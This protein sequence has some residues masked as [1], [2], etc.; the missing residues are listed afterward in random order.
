LRTSTNH[1]GEHDP[2]EVELLAPRHARRVTVQ[3]HQ[4]WREA[5]SSPAPLDVDD[6][7]LDVPHPPEMRRAGDIKRLER[8]FD[9]L[10]GKR[11]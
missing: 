10:E 3:S 6:L 1:Q 2:L 11:A 7:L 8:I 5:L 4:Q 9:E